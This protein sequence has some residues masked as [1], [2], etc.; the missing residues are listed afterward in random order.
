[1]RPI[2]KRCFGALL[3]SLMLIA[4]PAVAQLYGNVIPDEVLNNTEGNVYFGAV[5]DEHGQFLENATVVLDTGFIEYVAVTD[6][7]GR[8]RLQL[9]L[10]VAPGQ[11]LARCSRPGFATSRLVRRPPRSGAMTPVEISCFLE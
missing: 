4:T 10:D 1:M 9:P 5:R 2:D 7:R 6:P 11:V 8:Y 3:G